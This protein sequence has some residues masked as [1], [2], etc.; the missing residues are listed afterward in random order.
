MFCPECKMEYN[1]GIHTCADCG[2]ALVDEL[3]KESH[4]L[5]HE[6]SFL[7]ET[8]NLSDIALIES[9]LKGSGIKYQ[10]LGEN[11]NLMQP[12][13]APAKFYVQD[14]Q[15][16]DAQNLLKDVNLRYMGLSSL[17]EDEDGEE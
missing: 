15:L 6:Y 16:E 5:E 4:E 13:V 11:F 10:I 2:I 9:I 12:L 3:P 14:N 17:E 7:V 1:P 8:L